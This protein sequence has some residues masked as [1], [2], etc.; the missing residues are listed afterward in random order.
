MET[1]NKIIIVVL[2]LV[3]G[4]IL[5][6]SL[7]VP[8]LSDAQKTA[9]AKV[10]I[11][12]DEST[13]NSY[14]IGKVG[15]TESIV[16]G[17]DSSKLYVNDVEVPISHYGTVGTIA[18]SDAGYVGVRNNGAALYFFEYQDDG[19]TVTNTITTDDI[20]ITAT[21]ISFGDDTFTTSDVYSIGAS[22]PNKYYCVTVG[23]SYGP[24]YV[25]SIKDVIG[26][27][28]YTIGAETAIVKFNGDT[29]TSSTTT[30]TVDYTLDKDDKYTDVYQLMTYNIEFNDGSVNA[31]QVFVPIEFAGHEASG[32]AYALYG[33]IAVLVVIAI[34]LVAVKIVDSRR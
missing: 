19:T 23:S 13:H 20:T 17:L 29:A 28:T 22:T 8:V 18:F 1:G 31:S 25:S 34:L 33:S 12:N 26:W 3:V 32:A 10:T 14:Q 27:G 5:V 2:T 4:I 15:S 30:V 6:G 24:I 21:S 11:E 16:I 7:L 9:G